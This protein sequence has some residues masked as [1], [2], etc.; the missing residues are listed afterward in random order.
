MQP[1][2]STA[3]PLLAAALLAATA[4]G[5]GPSGP[6]DD[7]DGDDGGNGEI[8]A[9]L[10]VEEVV[11]GLQS[12]VHLTAPPGDDRLFVLEQGGRIRVVRNGS[13]LP[14]P[15]LDL[16]D[17]VG[18]AGSEQGLLGLAFHPEYATT[19]HLFVNYTDLNGDTRVERYTVTADPDAADPASARSI[20]QVEQPFSNHNGGLVVFG[21]DGMLYVGLGDGGGAGDPRGN[22]QDPGTLLGSILRLDV[23]GGDPFAIP[24]DNPFVEDPDARDEIWAW[25]LRNPWRFAFDESAGVL[26]IA[27]VGQNAF[28]EVNAESADAGGL[29]YGWNV[30]EGA[31]CFD[32]PS[33]CDQTGLTPPVLEYENGPGG[34]CSVTGG[35]VYR[36]DRIPGIRGHYFYSDFCAGFLRSFRLEDGEA[37]DRREW[38]VG[39]LGQVTSFG[40][41]AAGE[42]YILSADGRV[43]RLVSGS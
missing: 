38:E 2:R 8:P 23:D 12:P 31:H 6:G 41:D 36:G 35:F 33:G 27:D 43:F 9:S 11:A 10:A 7:G 32:P 4:C 3:P 17:R 21:P 42:L 16:T 5:S 19:G 26:Y 24:A 28:E 37:V 22:G 20:L 40:V 1:P 13:L 34:T 14:T 39:D 25:G 29:N 18:S 30:M 15:F